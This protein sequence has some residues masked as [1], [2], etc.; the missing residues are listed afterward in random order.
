VS[1]LSFSETMCHLNERAQ[2]SC[3]CLPL[4]IS[5]MGDTHVYFIRPLAPTLRSEPGVLQNLHRNSAAGLPQK[6]SQ[7][8]QTDMW[9]GWHGFEQRIINNATDEWCKRH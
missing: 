5:E 8:E 1:S 3:Q 4:Q 9:Y 2:P 6:N 7:R